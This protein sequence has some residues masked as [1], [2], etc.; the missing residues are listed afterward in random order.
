MT[1]GAA[2]PGKRVAFELYFPDFGTTSV[3]ALELVPEG[4]GTKVTWPMNGDMGNNPIYRWM[5]MFM[6]KMVGPD[7]EAGLANLEAL[8]EKT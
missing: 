8:A 2:E 3:G 1:V 7:F 4:N 6:D 5:T